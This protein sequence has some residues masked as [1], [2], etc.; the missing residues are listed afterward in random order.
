MSDVLEIS[1]NEPL[2]EEKPFMQPKKFSVDTLP[3]CVL[4]Y[5]R[6][7][8]SRRNGVRIRPWNA[9]KLMQM[10]MHKDAFLVL[11][12]IND[13]YCLTD[14]ITSY[15][16]Q[17]DPDLDKSLLRHLSET[18]VHKLYVTDEA[19][20][21]RMALFKRRLKSN[22]PLAELSVINMK[23]NAGNCPTCG[24][25]CMRWVA[26]FAINSVTEVKVEPI[27]HNQ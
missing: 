19:S 5:R 11:C 3:K 8:S 21:Y 18:F 26:I 23:T 4:R 1:V 9:N 22:H 7:I 6:K 14:S 27:P 16:R 17:H 2:E 20:L 15:V 10:Y 13:G 12:F 25:N 24:K